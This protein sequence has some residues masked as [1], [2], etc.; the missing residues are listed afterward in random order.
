MS[1]TAPARGSVNGSEI[2]PA[3]WRLDPL[4][5]TTSAQWQHVVTAVGWLLAFVL[6]GPA[7]EEA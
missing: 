6:V 2:L 1:G 4:A 5:Q 7:V 3:W